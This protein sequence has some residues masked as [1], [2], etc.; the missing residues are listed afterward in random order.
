MTQNEI[1]VEPIIRG[2]KNPHAVVSMVY[3]SG[4]SFCEALVLGESLRRGGR[5]YDTVLFLVGHF[6][7]DQLAVLQMFWD[8]LVPVQSPIGCDR[9]VLLEDGATED[10][11]IYCKFNAFRLVEYKKVLY[12]DADC[13]VNSGIKKIFSLP[14]PAACLRL[15][16]YSWVSGQKVDSSLL[17]KEDK[18]YNGII[19]LGVMLLT[20]SITWYEKFVTA[21]NKDG[22]WLEDNLTH[23][24]VGVDYLREKWHSLS[25]E[26]NFR[27]AFVSYGTGKAFG[28]DPARQKCIISHFHGKAKACDMFFFFEDFK[29]L[30]EF[31]NRP[32]NNLINSMVS[33][34]GFPDLLEAEGADQILLAM[35]KH[36]N[37]TFTTVGQKVVTEMGPVL[38]RL[39]KPELRYDLE[40][41]RLR[42]SEEADKRRSLR[43]GEK[44]KIAKADLVG[45]RPG[46]VEM[47]SSANVIR[48]PVQR[49][50]KKEGFKVPGQGQSPYLEGECNKN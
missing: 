4:S 6:D 28:A 11:R 47:T 17:V 45:A 9:D 44:F 49:S 10:S 23:E 33:W 35:H 46:L 39:W 13:H 14:T 42:L 2:A 40:A 18:S 38:F 21:I 43:S 26:Y 41:Y 32:R 3:G 1:V 30:R 24:D 16:E 50:G 20:P 27:P 25:C 31:Y 36:W 22:R 12:L 29:P 15:K 8:H 7:D 5:D 34:N 37:R 48:L 19:N